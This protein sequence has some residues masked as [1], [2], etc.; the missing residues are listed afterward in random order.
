MNKI[1]MRINNSEKWIFSDLS[2]KENTLISDYPYNNKKNYKAKEFSL[3]IYSFFKLIYFYLR[4]FFFIDSRKNQM[5]ELAVFHSG[6]GYDLNNIHK[7][8]NF[9][10]KDLLQ[11]NVFDITDFMKYEKLELHK[12]ISNF[13]K[14]ISQYRHVLISGFSDDIVRKILYTGLEVLPMYSYLKTFFEIL[15]EKHPNIVIYSGGGLLASYAAISAEM[16]TI[17]VAHGLTSYIDP[18]LFPKYDSIYLYSNDEKKYLSSIGIK[19]NLYMYPYQQMIHR[20]KAI[21]IF[22]PTALLGFNSKKDKSKFFLEIVNFFKFFGYEIYVKLHP[23]SN[24][25][26]KLLKEYNYEALNLH[27]ILDFSAVKE[28]SGSDAEIVINKI[29]PSFVFA[30]WGR[31]RRY[32][33]CR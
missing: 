22:M 4:Q 27:N 24:A 7:I 28:I 21:V 3:Y 33:I 18:D 25:P 16:K 19:S 20:N 30:G 23:L 9:Y 14:S 32:I 12:L 2:I 26:S 11:V 31:S 6:R 15:A 10:D 5:L 8:C 13:I 17:Y 29:R 1:N